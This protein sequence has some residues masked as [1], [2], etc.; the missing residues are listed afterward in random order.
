[1]IRRLVMALAAIAAFAPNVAQ[2]AERVPP[3][4]YPFGQILVRPPTY[5][6]T[7][8]GGGK[9][10]APAML[11]ADD[12]GNLTIHLGNITQ[13]LPAKPRAVSAADYIYIAGTAR[14]TFP[15]KASTGDLEF[16]APAYVRS[17]FDSGYTDKFIPV[18]GSFA[19]FSTDITASRI[20]LTFNIS[21]RLEGRAPCKFEVQATYFR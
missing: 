1:M 4:Y 14:M 6:C 11:S 21:V 17:Y 18:I 5:G 19:N 12:Q 9:P 20:I 3:G 16:L 10:E 2:S 8:S 15:N 13:I 7:P